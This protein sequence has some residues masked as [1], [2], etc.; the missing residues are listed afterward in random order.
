LRYL[1]LTNRE[2]SLWKGECFVFD[3]RKTVDECLEKGKAPDISHLPA[4]ERPGGID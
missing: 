4:A 3:D 2:E 1:E